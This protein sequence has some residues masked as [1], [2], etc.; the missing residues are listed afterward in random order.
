MCAA[1]SVHRRL[2]EQRNRIGDKTGH[3]LRHPPAYFV[4]FQTATT[5]DRNTIDVSFRVPRDRV[6]NVDNSLRADEPAQ[7]RKHVAAAVVVSFTLSASAK[8]ND[9]VTSL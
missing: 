4:H 1:Y 5:D 7:R 6:T 2:G 8:N 3:R 9:V